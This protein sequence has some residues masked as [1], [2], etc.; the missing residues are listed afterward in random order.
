M[1][2]IE[3]MIVRKREDSNTGNIGTLSLVITNNF[4]KVI[5][6]NKRVSFNLSFNHFLLITTSFNKKCVINT[7]CNWNGNT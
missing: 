6:Y 4:L 5:Q 7:D 3:A 1:F 2:H